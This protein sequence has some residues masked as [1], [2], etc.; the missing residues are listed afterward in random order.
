MKVILYIQSEA[1]TANFDT[2]IKRKL[3]YDIFKLPPN[4]AQIMLDVTCHFV[5]AHSFSRLIS[6][7]TSAHLLPISNYEALLVSTGSK[8]QVIFHLESK[9]KILDY[10][11]NSRKNEVQV[12]HG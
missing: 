1:I 11:I 5:K 6:L 8:G 12:R 3:K 4:G 7:K 2:Q 10:S 9:M